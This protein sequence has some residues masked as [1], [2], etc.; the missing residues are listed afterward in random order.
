[1]DPVVG[2]EMWSEEPTAWRSG[3]PAVCLRPG[4]RGGRWA[5]SPVVDVGPVKGGEPPR[6]GGWLVKV[7]VQLCELNT[8]VVVVSGRTTL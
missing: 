6:P 5:V 8:L 4:G 2:G 3:W 7:V 1:M